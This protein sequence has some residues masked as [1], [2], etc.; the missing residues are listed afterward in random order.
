MLEETYFKF[1]KNILPKMK[2]MQPNFQEPVVEYCEPDQVIDICSYNH[3]PVLDKS[4]QKQEQCN[5][6]NDI[7]D[8]SELEH[9][10]EYEI[11]EDVLKT[12]QL[13]AE[14]KRIDEAENESKKQRDLQFGDFPLEQFS[15]AGKVANEGDPHL[16]AAA[17]T[18]L[19]DLEKRAIQIDIDKYEYD[20]SSENTDD[21]YYDNSSP[22]ADDNSSRRADDDDNPSPRADD[23]NAS[24]RA[25]EYSSQCADDND[26]ILQTEVSHVQLPTVAEKYHVKHDDNTLRKMVYG[27]MYVPYNEDGQKLLLPQTT[28]MSRKDNLKLLYNSLPEGMCDNEYESLEQAVND[29]ETFQYSHE[30]STKHVLVQGVYVG[31]ASPLI[32]DIKTQ[33][34]SMLTY[35]DDRM[36]TG[37]YDNTHDIPIYIDNGSTL[38]IM[39]THFYDNAYYLHHL[40]KAPTAA[41]TIQTGNGPVKTHF[42][43]DIL[44]NVQGC[45]IQFKLLVCDTQAQTGILLSKMALEQL[46]TWQDYSNN[47]LYIKQTA[48]PLHAIQNIELLPDRKT[49]IEVVA[50]RTNELQYKELIEGQGIVWVW[51]NDSSKPLQPIVAMFHNNKTLITFENTTG[52]T[53]YIS[54]GAKVAILDMRSKDGGMT[55]FECD[56]PTDDEGN[57]VLYAHTF[58]SSLEPTKLANEDP[59]LQAE[60]KI[61]VSQT[62]NKHTI[63]TD[64]TEDPYP[65]LDVDDPRRTMTDEEILR[66]KVPFDKSILSAAE[67]ERLIKLMLENT[68]AFSIRDEI[69]TCPYFEVKLKLRD[70]KPFFV[71]PY[72]IREDQ[73]PI[74]QKEMDRLEKLGIIRKGLTGYSSPVLLV[75]RKQQNL[76]RVVTDFRVLNER[77]VRVNHAFPIVRD[78]LEAIGA[79]KCEVMSVLDLR[80]AYHTLPLAEESQKYCGLTPYYG[81]PTYVYLRMGMGMSCSPALWQQF[82]HII[83]EQLPNKER[84]KIIMDDILIFSTKEQHWEDLANLFEVLIRFGLKIS[85]HKCQLFR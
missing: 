27:P 67:K 70:D 22:R 12:E 9:E 64:N 66:L 85:P 36:M 71:R 4:S 42:W 83:W 60:M 24:H 26:D 19:Y 32:A 38:N 74:I 5:D 35:L 23:D 50:D 49:T 40:P 1:K 10:F 47:T 14:L 41:K 76:Y 20:N 39:P 29:I 30:M 62:P 37:T 15:D 54:K 28:D 73:K 69:G 46:Q 78:C 55:N 7:Y 72:N 82:V 53:Q 63:Q 48:I 13:M 25:E 31:S 81:S 33:P 77:L 52:Q 57:L 56:I 3:Y 6:N 44:L 43:I 84:Y 17:D 16:K 45:M 8:T 58:A 34:Y 11:Y 80:D 18:E 21:T 75:K 2:K 79:S 59:M 51:S 65:W 61:K 68:A